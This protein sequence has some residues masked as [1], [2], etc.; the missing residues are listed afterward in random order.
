MINKEVEKLLLK[1]Q[2]PGRYVGGEMNSVVKDKSKVNVRFAFCFPDVY[3]VGMSHLGM[4]ILYSQFNSVED[5]W[6]ERVFAPWI[7][8]EKLMREKNIP[9]YGLESGDPLTDFDFI[10]FTLQYELS[11]TNILNMLDLGG[12]PIKSKDRTEL[13]NIVCAGGP[14]ACN[15]EPIADFIDLFFIGEGEEVDLEVMNLYRQ[16]KANGDSKQEFLIKASQIKGVYV[17]SLYEVEYNEDNTI[18]SVTPTHNAPEKVEKR[19]IMNMDDVF[20][21]KNFVVPMIEIVHDRAMEEIF[22]GCIRG[23]RFCQAGF[24]YRPV[25]EKSTEVINNQCHTLCNNTGY[26]EVSLS[27]LSS[28]DYTEIGELLTKLTEWSE[29]EK[30]SI[31][32]PSLRVDGFNDEIISKIKTVRKS[33]LTF[34]PEAGT[35]RLR[36][37]INKNVF[38]DELMETCSKAFNGGWT[39]V[40]LYFMIGLP[41]ETDED[42]CGIADLGQKVVNTYYNCEN[43]PKG[44]G[45][46]VTLSTS[47]FVPKPFTP[48]QWEPQDTEEALKAKQKLVKESI[49]TKKITYNYHDSSTSFLE[50]VFARGDRRLCKVMEL[51]FEKGFH[52]DGW[53]DCFNLENWLQLFEECGI[54][55]EFYANRRRSFDEVLPWDHIDYGVTKE[56]LINECKKAYKAETTFNCRQKCSNCGANKWKGGVCIEK[57]KNMV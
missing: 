25:R 4:K 41:T 29:N 3:E 1:V 42:V 47:S 7:D 14:C 43:R 55:P 8:M 20:Y 24:L 44:K 32:L 45:V 30:V 21:P 15:P 26:D 35:Q 52:F 6:C 48:F 2:K 51:A 53:S 40:K 9:L 39:K 10:G 17:P 37:V 50:A 28:S 22:R 57:R 23:C 16:C 36:N 11:F 13:K 49:K 5:I 31:S 12:I 56:F 46:S 54:S 38:E 27:S 18:K 34:A 19:L 33:G